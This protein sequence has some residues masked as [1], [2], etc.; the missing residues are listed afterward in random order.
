MKLYK[1]KKLNKLALWGFIYPSIQLCKSYYRLQI[2]IT[3]YKTDYYIT[4]YKK[5]LS[6]LIVLLV[7]V[8]FV[9]FVKEV[10]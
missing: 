5:N 4:D 9:N 7:S 10:K 2:I 8:N 3:D 6:L 1:K